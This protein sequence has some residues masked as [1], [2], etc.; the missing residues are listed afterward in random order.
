MAVEAQWHEQVSC[1]KQ[2]HRGKQRAKK[3]ERIIPQ[4]AKALSSPDVIPPTNKML[5]VWIVVKMLEIAS[6][7]FSI[8]LIQLLNPKFISKGKV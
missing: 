8:R 5:I 6:K 4:H 1:L 3:R 2:L 7:L